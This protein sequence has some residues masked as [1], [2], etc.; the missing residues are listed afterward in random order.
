VD[1]RISGKN[2][3]VTQGMKDHLDEKLV[4]LGKYAPRLVEAHVILKK[5]KYIFKAE[6]TLLAKNL[7]A[8]G[9]AEAKDNIFA[10]IDPAYVRVEK[11]LKKYREKVKD[12]HRKDSSGATASSQNPATSRLSESM[13][14]KPSIVRTTD[15]ATKPMSIEESSL[16]LNM[17][18]RP[19]LVFLNA[20]SNK[21]NVI[22]KRDDGNHGLIEPGY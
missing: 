8:F 13:G 5:E 2:L 15:F 10:A 4:K 18:S 1:I 21:V 17:S 7:K 20:A 9:K 11:Q 6:I 22:Y 12:H 3:S 19:F 14:R 16:Q